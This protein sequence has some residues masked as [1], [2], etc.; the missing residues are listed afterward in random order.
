MAQDAI[1]LKELLQ[2]ADD[3]EQIVC[4]I[5]KIGSGFDA[6]EET[7]LSLLLFFKEQG[8]LDQLSH[9]R[10]VVAQIVV[11]PMTTEEYDQWIEREQSF[12]QPPYGANRDELLQK[13][14]HTKL[15][16]RTKA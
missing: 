11:S 8:V 5:D 3:L 15:P 6:M 2:T 10:K 4:V 1:H 12:W 13:I 16:K 14:T 9:A 7:A